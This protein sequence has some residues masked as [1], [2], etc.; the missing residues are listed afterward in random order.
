MCFYIKDQISNPA[1]YT[2]CTHY[3][4]TTS[5]FD[6]SNEIVGT[7]ISYAIR[8]R[9]DFFCF[10]LDVPKSIY[11]LSWSNFRG[12][13]SISQRFHETTAPKGL[14][15]QF[16]KLADVRK[17][18]KDESPLQ[19]CKT[20]QRRADYNTRSPSDILNFRNFTIFTLKKTHTHNA[21]LNSTINFEICARHFQIFEKCSLLT[22][23]TWLRS[24]GKI[25]FRTKWSI[26]QIWK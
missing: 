20:D 3:E 11:N 6:W 24:L 16:P 13:L 25:D 9:D 5:G 10:S 22:F 12:E 18:A 14:W 23:P 26:F 8:K 19:F 21:S 17:V 2:L 4:E 15:N 7:V 1:K